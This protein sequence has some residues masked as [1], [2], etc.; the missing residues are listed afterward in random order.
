MIS[1]GYATPLLVRLGSAPLAFVGGADA[2]KEDADAPSAR[3]ASFEDCRGRAQRDCPPRR[4]CAVDGPA[5]AKTA[6]ERTAQLAIA[7][8]DDRQRAGSGIVRRG[9]HQARS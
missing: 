8:R 7:G 5:D 1:L 6:G 9:W 4:C 2:S 3:S